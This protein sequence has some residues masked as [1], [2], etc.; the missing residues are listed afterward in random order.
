MTESERR[1]CIKNYE[2]DSKVLFYFSI[3]KLENLTPMEHLKL[4]SMASD[5]HITDNSIKTVLRHNF[6]GRP[7]LIAVSSF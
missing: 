4:T 2:S 3:L 5:H 6:V 7:I 1:I